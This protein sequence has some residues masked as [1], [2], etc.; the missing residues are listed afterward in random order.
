MSMQMKM[1]VAALVMVLGSAV[2][3]AQTKT[4]LPP[5]PSDPATIDL[6]RPGGLDSGGE[7]WGRY[8]VSAAQPV[9]GLVRIG[10]H[11]ATRW[12][13]NPAGPVVDF[14]MSEYEVEWDIAETGLEIKAD[15][16]PGYRI[17]VRVCARS[18]GNIGGAD[19]AIDTL[20]IT[21][22][23]THPET[24][25]ATFDPTG[26]GTCKTVAVYTPVEAG[27]DEYTLMVRPQ[28]QI[29]QAYWQYTIY[30]KV[31]VQYYPLLD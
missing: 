27:A 23:S 14:E 17:G 9:D 16:V 28:L 11:H 13:S 8:E 26:A 30:G 5:P 6:P 3:G 31:T 22:A 7:D 29:V 2:A 20:T 25:L 21:G 15:Y 18:N 19:G 12:S 24:Q 1:G 10:A 4:T